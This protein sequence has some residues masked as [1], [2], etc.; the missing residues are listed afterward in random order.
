MQKVFYKIE[1]DRTE[2]LAITESEQYCTAQGWTYGTFEAVDGFNYVTQGINLDE[3]GK[4]YVVDITKLVGD[5]KILV[6]EKDK[7]V[8]TD[9]I[10][11]DTSINYRIHYLTGIDTM[12]I[13]DKKGDISTIEGHL[14]DSLNN[15]DILAVRETIKYVRDFDD[16]GERRISST[17]RIDYFKKDGTV[18]LIHIPKDCFGNDLVHHYN[19]HHRKKLDEKARANLVTMSEEAGGFHIYTKNMEAETPELINPQLEE[20][21]TLFVTLDNEKNAYLKGVRNPLLDALA[22]IDTTVLLDEL[23]QPIPMAI[24]AGLIEILTNVLDIELY[25]VA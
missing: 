3:D 25:P 20:A 17:N 21:L 14:W 6:P 15:V 13:P 18:G 16:K 2:V 22:A 8:M 23:E 19:K 4:P 24:D 5:P 10:Q 11:V 1:E 9:S 7:L 12:G